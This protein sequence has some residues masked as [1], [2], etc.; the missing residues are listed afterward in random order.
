MPGTDG[1]GLY[2]IG[3]VIADE[4]QALQALLGTWGHSHLR[5]IEG[6]VGQT[7]VTL[8]E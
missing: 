5:T 6:E 1:P 3:P 4:L 2:C 7:S 8:I